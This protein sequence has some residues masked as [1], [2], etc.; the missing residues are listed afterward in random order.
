MVGGDKTTFIRIFT[1]RSFEHLS[2]MFAEYKKT[3]GISIETAIVRFFN[4]K[5]KYGM[6][7]L[8]T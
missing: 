2:F 8:G 7:Y 5:M 3:S 4:R 6:L 1:T